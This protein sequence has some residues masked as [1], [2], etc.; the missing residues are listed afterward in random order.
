MAV[1]EPHYVLLA[2]LTYSVQ[3]LSSLSFFLSYSFISFSY[4]LQIVASFYIILLPVR[5]V[6]LYFH[7]LFHLVNVVYFVPFFPLFCHFCFFLRFVFFLVHFFSGPSLRVPVFLLLLIPS[8]CM[9]S[10]CF[11]FVPSFQLLHR[12][13]FAVLSLSSFTSAYFYAGFCSFVFHIL[14][15]FHVFSFLPCGSLPSPRV[16]FPSAA[17][18]FL[19]C[20]IA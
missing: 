10:C 8:P 11:C 1:R 2:S 14:R 20:L 12:S 9:L 5:Y 4:S 18:F 16:S 3:P 6:I 7:F 15:S 19:L 13:L 17:L